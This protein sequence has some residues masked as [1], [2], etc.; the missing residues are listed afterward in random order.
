LFLW[1][2]IAH[3]QAN[4]AFADDAWRE[5]A[6]G[7]N[8]SMR[9]NL[10]LQELISKALQGDQSASTELVSR[11]QPVIL[12]AVRVH[13]APHDPLRRFFD[14]TDICQSVLMR[15]LHK[16]GKGAFSFEDAGGVRALLQEMAADKFIDKRREATTQ[17]RDYRRD[18][19][20]RVPGEAGDAPGPD[21]VR[22]ILKRAFSRVARQ[23]PAGAE[24]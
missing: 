1:P 21:A 11:L 17:R 4:R 7:E 5:S 18:E 3:S 13:L 20:A 6:A 9:V 12:R 24:M 8:L 10:D 14:S 19:I 2:A 22:M 16:A 23:V 15:F